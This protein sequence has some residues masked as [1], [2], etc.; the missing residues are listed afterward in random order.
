ME[1][2]T[3]RHRS[4]QERAALVALFEGGG[5]SVGQFCDREG[6]SLSSFQRWRARYS[7]RPAPP[8]PRPAAAEPS[9]FIDLGALGVTGERIELRL[10]LG[11]GMVLHLARG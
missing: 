10:D 8:T 1:R 7:A 6:V 4:A 2:A 11:G 3:R 9:A 5:L